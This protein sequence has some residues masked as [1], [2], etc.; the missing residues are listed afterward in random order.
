MKEIQNQINYHLGILSVTVEKNKI[1]ESIEK[2]LKKFRSL[3]SNERTIVF[4]KIISVFYKKELYKNIKVFFDLPGKNHDFNDGFLIFV[5]LKSLYRLKKWEEIKALHKKVDEE[6]IRN[7][8]ELCFKFISQA[9]THTQD[10]NKAISILKK[11][12]TFSNQIEIAKNMILADNLSGANKLYSNLSPKSL[13]EIADIDFGLAEIYFRQK[14]K[15][16]LN[17]VVNKIRGIFYRITPT[18][19][20]KRSLSIYNYLCFLEKEL[21]GYVFIKS[22]IEYK[23]NSEDELNNK[24]EILKILVEKYKCHIDE[25]KKLSL[26]NESFENKKKIENF[27]IRTF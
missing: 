2:I 4:K 18:Q 13:D 26:K 21:E 5:Y 16:L 10:Y 20:M 9:Y 8:R 23:S 6:N 15:F 24:I 25:L 12:N 27:F 3:R 7:N 14:N 17:E 1:E 11:N 22:A 19:L